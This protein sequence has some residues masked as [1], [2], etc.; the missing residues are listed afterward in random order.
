[1]NVCESVILGSRLFPEREAVIWEG[2]TLTY[3]QIER[4]SARAARWL[5]DLGVGRGDRV[6]MVLP[7]S[8]AF[9]VWY[10]AI[11]RRGAVAVSV[12]TRLAA[13]DLERYESYGERKDLPDRM[14]AGVMEAVTGDD[15]PDPQLVADAILDLARMPAGTRPLRTVVD[16]LMGG[17]GA[18]VLNEASD[19]IQRGLLEQLGLGG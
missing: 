6:G 15:A 13:S 16:P 9:V 19:E 1:M 8:A 14:W 10:Y 12:S 7:N 4:W 18:S 11:L 3:A 17:A 2:Q 5:L